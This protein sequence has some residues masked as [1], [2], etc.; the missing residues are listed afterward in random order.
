MKYYCLLS[1]LLFSLIVRGSSGDKEPIAVTTLT[2]DIK[3]SRTGTVEVVAGVTIT[4]VQ[5]LAEDWDVNA[6][7]GYQLVWQDEFNE[8]TT[9]GDDWIHEVQKSGWVNNE[10]QNYIAGSIDGKR[11][12]EL[13]DG[14]L[15]IN[16]FKGSDGKIYSGRVYAKANSGWKY[17][18]FEARILLPKGKGTWPALW[19][20]KSMEGLTLNYGAGE[21]KYFDNVW[22]REHYLSGKLDGVVVMMVDANYK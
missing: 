16:C 11:V 13:V 12:T 6:P 21:I 17:G 7:E 10:L 5:E 18:Y 14:K 8:G 2:N 4:V 20:D 19:M 3:T 15:N 1:I 9:L 22:V